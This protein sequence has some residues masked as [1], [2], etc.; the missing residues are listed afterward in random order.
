MRF[1]IPTD[2]VRVV[3]IG[4]RKRKIKRRP[5]GRGTRT[6]AVFEEEQM[7]TQFKGICC[8]VLSL[9]AVVLLLTV[10]GWAQGGTR[11][12][13]AISVSDPAGLM[14]NGATLKLVD[15]KTRDTRT[16]ETLEKGNY[17]FSGLLGG[18]YSLVIEKSGFQTQHF[19][20]IV[21]EAARTTDIFA[22]LQVGGSNVTVE[23]SAENAPLVESTASAIGMNLDT[24]QIEDLPL[25]DRNISGLANYTAGAA[26]GIFNGMKG[27]SQTNTIDGV[28]ATSS[29]G[30]DGGN[31]QPTN[32]PRI[33]N[34]EEMVVQTDQLDLNQGFGQANMQVGFTTRRGGDKYHGRVFSDLQ[35]SS[36]NAPGWSTDYYAALAG[37]DASRY[38]AKYH[39]NEFGGSV[40]GPVP[41]GSFKG[42]LF[43]FAS[44]SQDSVPGSASASNSYP[45]ASLQAGTYTYLGTD[46]ANHTVDL[47][48][49][50]GGL[51]IGARTAINA[52]VQNE[53]TKINTAV[54][55][56]LAGKDSNDGL[57]VEDV[58]FN[59]A[60]SK[61]WY[62]PT[63]RVDYNVKDNLRV[64]L[65]YNETKYSAPTGGM[66]LYPGSAYDA[67]KSKI[68]SAAYTASLGVEWTIK[69]TL[70]NQLRGGYLYNASTNA[71]VQD[72]HYMDDV[73][74]WAMPEISGTGSGDIH[75]GRVNTFYPL[76]S[77]S[78]NLV[79]QH[80]SHSFL[81]GFSGYREQDH[82][83]DNPQG[84]NNVVF[85]A[86]G[87][88]PVASGFVDST[89]PY[90]TGTQQNIAWNFY[91]LLSGRLN[92]IGLSDAVD[93]ATGTFK[94]GSVNL[95]ERQ[96]AW[97]IFAQDSYRV[98]PHLTLNYGMRWDFT[99]DDHDLNGVY[100]SVTRDDV[101]GPT[102]YMNQF[103][104][105]SFKNASGTPAFTANSHAYSPW[106]ISPQPA[107]GLSWNPTFKEG[108]L[109]NL[110][111]ENKTVIRAGY[112]LR[113]YTESY[114]NFWNYASNQGA[115][116]YNNTST[117]AQ[118][119][120][121]GTQAK[122]TFAPGAYQW[123]DTIPA[124]A[125]VTDY[126]TYQSSISE[127]SLGFLHRDVEGLDKHIRQP[128]IQSWNLGVQ[129]E[130]GNK[131]AIE[132]RY[133][134]NHGVEEWIPLNPNEVNV[135]ENGFLSEFKLAQANAKASN[136]ASF[137]GNN[138]ATQLPIMSAAFGGDATQFTNQSFLTYLQ[139][140]NVGQFAHD[141]TNAGY[142]CNMLS[143]LQTPCANNAGIANSGNGP[144]ASNF[145]VANPWAENGAGYA[146][147][148]AAYMTSAG[149]SNYHSLQVEFRQHDFHGM[150]FTAN[151]TFA[152]N[153]GVR[154]IKGGDSS[155]FTL[156]TMRNM[157]MS[158][159]PTDS[160]IRQT[161]NVMGTYDLPVGKG[162]LLDAHNKLANAVVGQWTLGTITTFH[163]GLPFQLTGGYQT[164][165]DV[166]DGGINLTGVSL[167]QLRKAVGIHR[168][169]GQ[170]YAYFIDPKYLSNTYMTSNTTPGTFAMRPWLWAPHVFNT[171]LSLSKGVSIREGVKFS[172]QGEF[173]NAFN[174]PTWGAGN[175]A[176]NAMGAGFGQ[177][178][179]GGSRTIEVRANIEF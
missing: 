103:N 20:A 104:P 134:G 172:L 159:A 84:Y 111:G 12:T 132:I 79:W 89:M 175:V 93:R 158:Y 162:K 58:T 38:R 53:F 112:S 121:G 165:N 85:G 120:V 167:Q 2:R 174:H 5:Q 36:F 127:E 48:S 35:N 34:I 96:Q 100:H 137:A 37:K 163:T 4:P 90:S 129:R 17:T 59:S 179:P 80:K 87:G 117:T 83:W 141:L 88:D 86:V 81:V 139:Y 130:L 65:A 25:G 64:N 173:L 94:P 49:L 70:L 152:R 133:V 66:P 61:T 50:A 99:G 98:T 148:S 92:I 1:L 110:I 119:P 142:M 77:L 42:K 115:F 27:A 171:D 16:A 153:F 145:F 170:N 76:A 30:K 106:N 78:D 44:Y 138:P 26:N 19:D 6:Q 60:A 54:K 107:F 9:L 33:E 155:N 82:Y 176:V 3:Y 108:I 177:T 41:Y 62:Y 136:G 102:G 52:N 178:S 109:G 91:T 146:A 72:G 68:D 125:W 157:R 169:Q 114:Q 105:G 13:I 126:T 73:V 11:G 8:T 56:G 124:S 22:R 55:L 45:N 143:G 47:Y 29:R 149:N 166:A 97:G 164:F 140:G 101:W 67:T 147:S 63:F 15:L 118:A 168:V 135:F 23:V 95:D 57:N 116:F 74:W 144:Y 154:S 160:D 18:V 32:S 75:A 24:K 131:N 151:Y 156:V 40:G 71:A 31:F 122:G 14:V 39:K 128:Y 7:R 21:V 46:N 123:G 150:N 161:L 28:V 10:Q 113:N 43:F 69:P 51:G